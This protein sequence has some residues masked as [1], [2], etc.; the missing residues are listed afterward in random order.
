MNPERWQQIHEV[1]Q[2]ALQQPPGECDA[3]VRQ[4]CNG[5]ETLECEVR[6]LLRSHREAGSFLQ[7]PAL[8]FVARTIVANQ[9]EQ[10]QSGGALIGGTISHYRILEKV[11]GGG[12]GVVYRA[13][14]TRLDRMVAL[15]FLPDDLAPD[16]QALGRFKRESIMLNSN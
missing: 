11:G 8:E 16:P 9:N 3:F 10:A 5:D 4:T 1:L 7:S 13:V 12:M 2:S 15:K 6:S 14:D